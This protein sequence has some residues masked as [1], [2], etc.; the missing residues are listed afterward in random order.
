MRFCTY[1]E[2]LLPKQQ[3]VWAAGYDLCSAVDIILAP[4]QIRAIQTGVKMVIDEW[5]VW[6]V[7][8]RSSMPIK[9]WL[10]IPNW[11]G[12]IDSDYR[13]EVAVEIMNSS[14]EDK[15]IRRWD[16]I[17]QII[18]QKIPET[19]LET[20]VSENAFDFFDEV[21]PTERGEGWFWS[22]GI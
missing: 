19:E 8:L 3:T 1:D 14:N 5:Y 21:Y 22:T 7:C 12:V 9:H 4:W 17:W 6:I 20:T 13:W 10:T 15:Y 18:F 11:V 2:K 16:R